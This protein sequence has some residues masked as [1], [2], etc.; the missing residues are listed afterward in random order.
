[1]NT[2]LV[3][4]L[5][6][7][8][9]A[10]QLLL[11]F[12][13][14]YP[15]PMPEI[16]AAHPNQALMNQ[17][18]SSWERAFGPLHHSEEADLE[19]W[20]EMAARFDSASRA[21]G[22]QNARIKHLAGNHLESLCN[23]DGRPILPSEVA[24]LKAPDFTFGPVMGWGGR[25]HE[26]QIH[27]IADHYWDIPDF[28]QLSARRWLMA[29]YYP[30]DASHPD[31]VQ[32][33]QTLF[34]AGVRKF[35]VKGTASK[36]MLE[37]FELTVRPTNLYGS[38]TEIPDALTDGVMHLEG[39]SEVYMVQEFVPMIHEY[40]FFMAGNT[41]VASA[42]CVEHFTPLDHLGKS[43][44]D[45]QIETKRSASEVEENPSLV[46]RMLAFARD[47]GAMLFHQAPELG[48]AWVLDV[49]IN[50]ATGEPVVIE[51]NPARNAGLYA[52]DPEVWMI[53]VRNW[54]T[55]NPSH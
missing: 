36:T 3:P 49:A 52:S 27:N 37:I 31:I 38:E 51:T 15:A 54:V 26:T 17:Y 13:G 30:D 5:S 7:S 24:A 19:H 18:N 2:S 55:E 14:D 20:V 43:A 53:G 25:H 11:E 8:L 16:L 9:T 21:F 29:G 6:A 44:F 50:A 48:A 12:R 22:A 47:A 46:G 42:G 23:F 4:A 40:R 33:L 39:K 32:A 45:S 34:D 10:P 28:R 41:P 35:V 1:M